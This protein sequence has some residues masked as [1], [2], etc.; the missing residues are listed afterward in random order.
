M[1]KIWWENRYGGGGTSGKGSV[2]R[3]RNWK[4]R[5]IEEYVSTPDSVVDVGCGDLSFWDGRGCEDYLGIDIACNVITENRLKRPKWRFICA[6]AKDRQKAIGRIVL[7]LDLLFHIMNT[8]DFTAILEN[9]CHYSTEW[10]FIYTWS[11][12]P[13]TDGPNKEKWRKLGKTVTDDKF[14]YYR[15]LRDYIEIFMSHGF[16]LEETRRPPWDGIG[17][18]FIF[19][20]SELDSPL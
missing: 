5:M 9:L 12:N 1:E 8:D 10:I 15:P 16:L 13:F 20:K 18:L 11:I 2:G 19:R 3:G 17:E 6:N 14:Q 4:W 7:C